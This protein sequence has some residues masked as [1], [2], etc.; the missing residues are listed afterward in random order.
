MR[1]RVFSVVILLI[2]SGVTPVRAGTTVSSFDTQAQANAYAP[3][4]KSAY[5]LDDSKHNVSPAVGDV[6]GDWTGTN[7]GGTETTW[8]MTASAHASS[9]TT[10]TSNSLSITGAGSFSYE[11]A[12]TAGFSEPLQHAV[13]Y[14]PGANTGTG[15]VFTIDQPATYS[16]SATISGVSGI[17]LQS[18]PG[19][20]I[21]AQDHFGPLA[22]QVST[23]GTIA[24]GK[25]Q[26][27]ITAN[28]GGPSGLPNGINDILEA[29]AFSSFTFF[30]QVPEPSAG[31][32]GLCLIHVLKSRSRLNR[33]NLRKRRSCPMPAV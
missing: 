3:L 26:V 28:A 29:G 13:L 25:Y 9:T 15:A 6:V 4:D 10:I 2:C 11:I 5:F 16:L 20:I 12:T 18:F 19:T 14:T 8:H 17:A 7:V 30:V 32:M 23:S 24:P 27:G 22:K 1:F 21:F 33:F 31:V